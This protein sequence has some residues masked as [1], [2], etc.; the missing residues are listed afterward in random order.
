MT[1]V[2]T[3][4]NANY[5][6]GRVGQIATSG[7]CRTHSRQVETAAGIGFGLAVGQGTDDLGAVLGQSAAATGT[8][9]AHQFV[10]ISLIDTTRYP[11]DISHTDEYQRY[12]TMAVITDGEVWVSPDAAVTDGQAVTF[13]RTTGRMSAAAAAADQPRI[14]GARW[15][16]SAAANGIARV[17]LSGELG[18]A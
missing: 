17:L 5:A 1:P 13:N 16:T 7:P 9:D 3:T 14:R 6:V 12:D 2:Q 15:M 11:V 4:Y 18:A 10:G 8:F